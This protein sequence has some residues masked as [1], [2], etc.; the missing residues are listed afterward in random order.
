MAGTRLKRSLSAAMGTVAFVLRVS[1]IA[2]GRLGDKALARAFTPRGTNFSG[3]LPDLGR[4]CRSSHLLGETILGG[5]R[6]VLP[7]EKFED[8]V[9][10]TMRVGYMVL[11]ID[12]RT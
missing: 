11:V 4:L 3:V 12:I 7:I 8:R 1:Q 2:L 5:R 9:T 10:R 6:F